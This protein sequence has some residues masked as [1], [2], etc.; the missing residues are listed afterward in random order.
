[1]AG[2]LK[3][4]EIVRSLSALFSRHSSVSI[5]GKFSRLREIMMVLTADSSLSVVNENFA[6][7]TTNEVDAFYGLRI[8]AR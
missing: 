4:E 6:T 2:A 5:R 1:M 8:D 3:L 7:L